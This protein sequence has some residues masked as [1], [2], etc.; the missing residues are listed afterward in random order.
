MWE[1]DAWL[2]APNYECPDCT[3]R[4][5]LLDR[6]KRLTYDIVFN[7]HGRP[8]A[9]IHATTEDLVEELCSCLGVPFPPP[10]EEKLY[11]HS[12]YEG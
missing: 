8:N 6:C 12:A 1:D 7:M 3:D 5:V 10:N 9:P 2:C 11:G 4:D